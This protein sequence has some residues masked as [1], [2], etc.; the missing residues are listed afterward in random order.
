MGLEFFVSGAPG[1][2]L[3]HEGSGNKSKAGDIPTSERRWRHKQ[4]EV[5]VSGLSASR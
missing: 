5:P 2:E 1:S 4:E 3:G